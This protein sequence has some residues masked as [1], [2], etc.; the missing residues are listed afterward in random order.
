MPYRSES[1][2]QKAAGRSVLEICLDVHMRNTGSYESFGGLDDQIRDRNLLYEVLT[3]WKPPAGG[4][5]SQLFDFCV[6]Q[7]IQATLAETSH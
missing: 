5:N 6:H 4:F 3:T 1:F 2:T 7:L